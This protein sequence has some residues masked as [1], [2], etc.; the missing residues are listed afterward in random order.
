[1]AEKKATGFVLEKSQKEIID[2][3][4]DEEAGIIFKAIYE[5]EN[6]GEEPKLEK[7]LRIVFKQIKIKLDKYDNAY[8]DKCAKNKE[9]INKYWKEK[10]EKET[11]SNEFER[12][13]SNSNEY[14]IK[15]NKKEN[16]IKIKENKIKINNISSITTTNNNNNDT[17]YDFVQENFGRTLGPIEYEEVSSWEDS[18]LTRYAIKQS[19]LS[20]KCTIKYISRILDTYQR[21]NIKT[22]QQAQQKEKEYLESKE[23]QNKNY[24]TA[25]EKRF[26]MYR[27]LEEE[28]D[29]KTNE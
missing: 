23:K 19:V 29:N 11:Y 5:Y 14:K 2:E 10:K 20:G 26:E 15:E 3:L 7:T 27:R 28:Y 21:E 4:T 1:M 16:K 12:I 25:Q 17:I 24:K 6:T 8:Q 13:P 22:V 9:N 18:E